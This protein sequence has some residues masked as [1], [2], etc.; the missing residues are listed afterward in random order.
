LK[1]I[2]NKA[3]IA[4]GFA[5]IVTLGGCSSNS[6]VETGIFAD[7]AIGNAEYRCDS[8]IGFT[9]RGGEFNCPAGSAVS[10][11]FG[12]LKLGAVDILPDDKIVM[13]QDALGLD[14]SGSYSDQN[15]TNLAVL[16]QSLDDDNDTSNGIYLTSIPNFEKGTSIKD[17]NKTQ[18]QQIIGDAGK[19]VVT[20]IEAIEHLTQTTNNVNKYKNINGIDGS[21]NIQEVC[22][23]GYKGIYYNGAVISATNYITLDI[24]SNITLEFN[25][26]TSTDGLGIT[27]DL[28]ATISYIKAVDNNITFVYKA[29]L[30]INTDSS[31]EYNGT[32]I[33]TI[34]KEGCDSF[35]ANVSLHLD[36]P[37]LTS[38]GL[39]A[40]VD[41]YESKY[42]SDPNSNDT[43]TAAELIIKANTINVKSM[44]QLFK[45]DTNFNLD[46]SSWD[47]SSVINMDSMF[48]GAT[49]FNQTLNGWDTSSVQ[50]MNTMFYRATSF[51]QTLND[52]NTSSV[53]TMESMFNSAT[54]F[55]QTLNDWDT[56][57]VTT[58]NNMFNKASAFNQTLNGWDTSSVQYMNSMFYRAY[59]FNQSLNDW[60][61]S[62]VEY[63]ASMFNGATDFNQ[64]INDWNT[65]S[66]KS[67]YA[68]FRDA[69]AFNRDISSWD[70][71][72]V[73]NMDEMFKGATAFHDQ[74]L[75]NW[76]VTSVNSHSEFFT[77]PYWNNTPPTW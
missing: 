31:L 66:V 72:S 24:D 14:R 38:I 56:S 20:E 67:M 71:S 52:W 33:L 23:I 74:N 32:D 57:S 43:S 27:S 3:L 58:I 21:P 45:D 77:A 69:I 37:S 35:D 65:S 34:A 10:F 5:V 26:T 53:T 64:S 68:M 75:S 42:T 40:L 13:I 15:L 2:L 4:I 7:G 62:S 59:A 41:D 9:S 11:Y 49:S 46:I 1:R 22:N 16:L 60:D 30:K 39:Q 19:T 8:T 50:Y 47:T 6:V 54:A 29:P 76:D 18:I 48:S 61:T 70:T 73:T 51:N 63:V 25:S 17:L 55:N 28:N 12:N 44:S 36:E